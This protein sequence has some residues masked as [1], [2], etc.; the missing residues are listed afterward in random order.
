MEKEAKVALTVR[1]SN[2]SMK[3]L[4]DECKLDDRSQSKI[5]EKMIEAYKAGPIKQHDTMIDTIAVNNN[6]LTRQIAK[7]APKEAP[8]KLSLAEE[9]ARLRS[10]Q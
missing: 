2:A 10:A 7:T 6:G 8:K 9:M 3:K 1:I 5:I 4:N